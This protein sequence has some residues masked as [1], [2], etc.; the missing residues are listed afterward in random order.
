VICRMVSRYG[1]ISRQPFPFLTLPSIVYLNIAPTQ[2]LRQLPRRF[3]TF[4]S[5]IVLLKSLSPSNIMLFHLISSI[6]CSQPQPTHFLI[7][8]E[9]LPNVSP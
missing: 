8:R 4:V 7:L 5:I 3:T 6:R 9:A 1:I 2:F